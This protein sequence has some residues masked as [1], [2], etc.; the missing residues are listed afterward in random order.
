MHMLAAFLAV[1]SEADRVS[2]ATVPEASSIRATG[3]PTMATQTT[4]APVPSSC[5]TPTANFPPQGAWW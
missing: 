2:S 4:R 5:D 1:P 3:R